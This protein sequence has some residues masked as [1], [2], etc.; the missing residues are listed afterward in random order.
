[1]NDQEREAH[2]ADCGRL[3]I[4]AHSEGDMV[5]ARRW[6]ELQAE[7]VKARTPQQVARMESC[8]FAAEGDRSRTAAMERGAV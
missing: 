5:A 4:K 3:F 2:I 7:A 6:L 8:Y 1:M